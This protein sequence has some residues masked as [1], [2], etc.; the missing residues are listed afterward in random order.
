MIVARPT[1][2][3]EIGNTASTKDG[4]TFAWEFF[5]RGPGSGHVKSVQVELHPP[6]A[7]RFITLKPPNLRLRSKGWGTFPIKV[8][9]TWRGYCHADP[10]KTVWQLQF[11][12]P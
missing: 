10:L 6:F 1:L 11:D 8:T 4:Q 9:V 5:V 7:N 12:R 2:D 3:L